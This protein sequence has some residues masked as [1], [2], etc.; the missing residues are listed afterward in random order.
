ME[1]RIALIGFGHVGRG[2]AE[3]LIEKKA[4]L[5]ERWA[6]DFKVTAISTGKDGNFLAL[7]GLPVPQ[8]LA[9]SRKEPAWRSFHTERSVFD[10]IKSQVADVYCELSPTNLADAQPALSLCRAVLQSGKHL[11]LANKG[12]AALAG[13]ELSRLAAEKNLAFY[14]EATV[15]S[16]CPVFSLVDESLAHCRF[17]DFAGAVNGTANFIISEM[18]RDLSFSEALEQARLKGYTETDPT[19]DIEG[20][21][22]AAKAIILGRHL[23][24]QTIPLEKVRR[25]GIGDLSAREI[26]AAGQRGRCLRLISRGFVEKGQLRLEVMPL[27]IP[28]ADPLALAGSKQSVLTIKTDLL[29]QLT[30]AGPSAGGRE[31]AAGVLSDL[32]RLHKRFAKLD[33]GCLSR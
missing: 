8:M 4:E 31:T 13:D 29:G 23:F 22:S 21:D 17:I 10:L 14:Q 20:L 15:M 30:I 28:L 26:T 7:Q 16:G 12:P 18:E 25:R 1:W 19:L 6:F 11:V 2:L 3:L 9:F 5:K 32:L 24:R 27:E 33:P